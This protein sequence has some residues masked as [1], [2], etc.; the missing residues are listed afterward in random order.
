MAGEALTIQ[1]R[2]ALIVPIK[3]SLSQA[4][5]LQDSSSY[6]DTSNKS[7]H[8]GAIG[9]VFLLCGVTFLVVGLSTKLLVF[10]T[11]GPAF[12]TLGIVF[13]AISKARSRKLP[14]A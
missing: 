14:G 11:I 2:G 1:S 13:L 8:F 5:G 10:S 12:L 4:L 7:Q 6:M 3:V 9:L